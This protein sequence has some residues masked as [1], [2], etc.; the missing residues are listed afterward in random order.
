MGANETSGVLARL[1]PE[2][3][4]RKE[5]RPRSIGRSQPF[6]QPFAIKKPPSSTEAYMIYLPDELAA[7]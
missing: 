3:G 2:S 1:M 7:P 6:C 5:A 4:T